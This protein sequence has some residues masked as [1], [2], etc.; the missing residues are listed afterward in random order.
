MAI[1]ISTSIFENVDKLKQ[2][3]NPNILKSGK[4]NFS[5]DGLYSEVIFGPLNNNKCA[6]GSLF[7]TSNKNK[8]CTSCNV[9]CDS[10]RLRGSTFAR[11]DLPKNIYVVYPPHRDILQKIFG[12]SAIK[13]LLNGSKYEANKQKPYFYSLTEM[14][15]IKV[16]KLKK[17]EKRIN[18]EVYDIT[19]LYHLFISMKKS[20]QFGD[21]IMS[22]YGVEKLADFT[23][24]NF[25]MVIPPDSRPIAK[26]N[27]QF[28]AHPI[29]AAYTEILKNIKSSFLDKIFSANSSGFGQ[30]IYK[31]Q[32]SVDKL[33]EEILNKNFQNKE[34]I[35]KISLSGKTVETSQRSVIVPDP[36]LH[37]GSV[38]L[39]EESLLKL[40]LP[41]LT[42]FVTEYYTKHNEKSFNLNHFIKSVHNE[43]TKDGSIKLTDDQL[44]CF[45][46]EIGPSLRCMIERP[47]VLWAYNISGALIGK[48]YKKSSDKHIKADMVMGVNPV[49]AQFFNFDFDGDTMA[50]YAITSEQAKH[51]FPKVAMQNKIEF[52]H[53]RNLLV[54]L[55]HESIYAIYMLSVNGQKETNNMIENTELEE[56]SFKDICITIKGLIEYPEAK[57]KVKEGIYSYATIAINQAFGLDIIIY[58]G[59]YDIDKSRLNQLLKDM[60]NYIDDSVFYDYIHNL[61]KF[62]LEISTLIQDCN[63]SFDLE[64]FAI[65]DETI[66]VY[67]KGLVTEP[68]IAFHQNDILFKDIVS[69]LVA[70]RSDNIL[71]RV[72]KSKARIKSVQ[73]LKAVS[74]NGIPTDIYGKAFK[75]NIKNSL[76]DG[77]TK[78]EFFKSGD[79]ARLALAQR[80]EAIPRGGE[81]QR[82]F[83]YCTGFL[84]LS[85][86]D[87]CGSTK[88][89]TIEIY[90]KS[91]LETMYGR[92]LMNGE[93][94]DTT[95]LTLIGKK[96]TLRSP[97]GCRNKD[98]K[99]CK[100]CFGK[101][102]P[103]S[104]SLGAS[105]GSFIS[106]AI[107]QSVLRTHHFSG[108]F[109]TQIDNTIRDLIKNLSFKENNMIICKSQ[110]DI[111]NINKLEK[112]IKGMYENEDSVEFKRHPKKSTVEI[113]Q[114][115]TPF[116]DDSVK[117]LHKIIS[118]IDKNREGDDMISPKEMYNIL[119]DEIILPNGI[120][121]I[122]VELIISIL[123][124]D[125][126]GQMIRYSSFSEPTQQVALKNVIDKLDPKLSIFHNFSNRAIN[127]IYTSK[128]D[129]NLEH[130]FFSLI[131]CYK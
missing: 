112:I 23:F 24:V 52:E 10:S 2:V 1:E 19:T 104:K 47:P 54:S 31:Y 12:Q 15:L 55:E 115:D 69:P 98:Y 17:S 16:N 125:E 49:M 130:M 83:Y 14:K 91:H 110:D 48:V 79:S 64:D 33:Y 51:E 59:T 82:K 119:R 103:Q 4:F 28:Q 22:H 35:V 101:K 7:G 123:F 88:G 57:V 86:E 5:D 113:I 60:R 42:H 36:T 96:I 100:K 45:I 89:F 44:D 53:N 9:L 27:G 117:Q 62:L 21:I 127:K 63:C 3:T 58:D 20:E 90:N 128:T 6:C 116:N 8:R 34:S 120:L 65:H 72:F 41:E 106:E 109:I 32:G 80:Q 26:L 46:E 11:I 93:E 87:D 131:N 114:H 122:Y 50:A 68:Y 105:I 81:L 92:Y 77:L 30:T 126:T 25:I 75:E 99:I 38:A 70:K 71:N 13:S 124:Y 67:K 108:A 37:P 95:D 85:E 111:D 102:Q 76:L 39:T 94:I 74:N 66:P 78:A 73:L 121:S 107:I 40:F 29:T 61:D 56:V 129:N 18:K 118:V 43:A 97:Y 84:Y